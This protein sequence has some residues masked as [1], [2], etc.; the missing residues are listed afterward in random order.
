VALA[1]VAALALARVDEP[2]TAS[3]A[4]E[5]AW[6]GVRP[7]IAFVLSED[8]PDNTFRAGTMPRTSEI[9]T[10]RALRFIDGQRDAEDPFFLWLAHYAPHPLRVGQR[11]QPAG[12]EAS[13]LYQLGRDPDQLDN[14]ATPRSTADPV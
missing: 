13:E 8:Q 2:G 11:D 7:N 12:L 10:R 3:R 6:E 1:T 5:G 4:S 14:A 9:L